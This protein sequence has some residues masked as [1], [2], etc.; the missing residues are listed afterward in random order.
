[1][2]LN[3]PLWRRTAAPLP[4]PA[5]SFPSLR[6][7]AVGYLRRHGAAATARRMAHELRRRLRAR[8]GA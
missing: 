4:L 2:V 7:R 3:Y 5:S 6:Q 8:L 1:V